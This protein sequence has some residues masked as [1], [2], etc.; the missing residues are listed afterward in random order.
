MR[1]EKRHN[2]QVPK[3]LPLA[4]STPMSVYVANQAFGSELRVHWFT[5]TPPNLGARL[6]P[7]AP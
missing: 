6:R 7:C 3:R 4:V 5:T 1:S 2:A